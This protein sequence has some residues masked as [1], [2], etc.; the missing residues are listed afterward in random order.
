LA[1]W[2]SLRL[3]GEIEKRDGYENNV[4]LTGLG[5]QNGSLDNKNIR[6]T[7]RWA[8]TSLRTR[9]QANT[10]ARE[11]TRGIQDYAR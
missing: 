4:Y 11:A 9:P 6:A 1:S 3:A 8:V 5:I 2:A 10:V 7:L